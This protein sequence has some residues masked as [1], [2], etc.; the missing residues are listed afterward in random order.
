[1]PRLWQRTITLDYPNLRLISESFHVNILNVKCF[2]IRGDSV[3]LYRVLVADISLSSKMKG[4]SLLLGWQFESNAYACSSVRLHIPHKDSTRTS[5]SDS[6]GQRTG[7]RVNFHQVHSYRHC[8]LFFTF[9]MNPIWK[10]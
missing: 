5:V 1:M 7:F 9:E 4:H 10:M 2:L 8:I 6:N 3:K